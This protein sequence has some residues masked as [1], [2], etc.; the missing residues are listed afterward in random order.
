MSTRDIVGDA[1]Q[2]AAHDP[3]LTPELHSLLRER[4]LLVP[5]S[6]VRSTAGGSAASA[7]LLWKD[8]SD[9]TA[10][11]PLFS[12][13][14]RLPKGAPPTVTMVWDSLKRLTTVLPRAHFRI[15]PAGPVL[16]DLSPELAHSVANE[17]LSSTAPRAA[18]PAG[19]EMGLGRPTEDQGR[20]VAALRSYFARQWASPAVFLYEVHRNVV[21]AAMPALAIGVVCDFDEAIAAAVAAIVPEAYGGTLPVDITFIGGNPE[22]G[23]AL[24]GLGICP[25]VMARVSPAPQ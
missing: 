9:G 23:H 15:N 1:L 2:R 19:A 17:K 12:A 3:G 8:P 22:I 11:V 7:I 5:V 24:V 4:T 21:P 16:Y 20:L 14:A 18:F 25:I 10:F 6:R 13:T